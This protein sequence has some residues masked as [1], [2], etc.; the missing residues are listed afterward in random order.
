MPGLRLPTW[1]QIVQRAYEPWEAEH[2]VLDTAGQS[3]EQ[4]VAALLHALAFR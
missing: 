3:V 2:L 4:S 1:D